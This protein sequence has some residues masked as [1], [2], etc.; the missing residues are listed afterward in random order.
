MQSYWAPMAQTQCVQGQP[1]QGGTE[2]LSP[3]QALSAQGLGGEVCV[4]IFI[5]ILTHTGE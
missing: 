2:T 1:W 4:P 5:N 3:H